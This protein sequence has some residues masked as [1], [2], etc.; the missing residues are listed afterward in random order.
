MI[1]PLKYDLY[2]VSPKQ[3]TKNILI[4][5]IRVYEISLLLYIRRKGIQNFLSLVKFFGKF[6]KKMK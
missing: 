2:M 1:R 5:E 3:R 6:L 4:H